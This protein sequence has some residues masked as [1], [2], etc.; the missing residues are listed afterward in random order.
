MLQVTLYSVP[1]GHKQF[2]WFVK[3]TFNI[4]VRYCNAKYPKNSHVTTNPSETQYKY[5]VPHK[6]ATLLHT[7][8]LKSKLHNNHIH[9]SF[10][11]IQFLLNHNLD[12]NVD[13]EWAFDTQSCLGCYFHVQQLRSNKKLDPSLYAHH[14]N[15]VDVL[16]MFGQRLFINVRNITKIMSMCLT[17]IY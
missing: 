17:F 2:V 8:K 3:E 13:Y 9:L 11:H 16:V 15:H 10:S 14:E 4:C 1:A 6:T 7:L 5:Y 12:L